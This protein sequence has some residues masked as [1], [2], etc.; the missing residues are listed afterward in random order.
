MSKKQIFAAVPRQAIYSPNHVGNDAAIFNAVIDRIRKVGHEVN[1]YTEEEFQKRELS[2]RFIFSMVRCKE[3]I[4]RLQQYEDKGCIA[5][6]SGYGIENCTRERMTRLLIEAG[7]PHPRSLFLQKDDEVPADVF[8][9][10][11]VKRADFHAIHKE[12]VTYVRHAEELKGLLSEYAMRG[13]E[14]V[15]V[16]EHL[17]GDLIKFYGVNGTDFFYWFYPFDMKHSK[18]G[19]EKINGAPTGIPFDEAS[20][21]AN[22]NKAATVL[23]VDVYGGDAIVGADGTI[24]IIDFNDWPSFAPCREAAADAISERILKKA[25]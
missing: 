15:V 14:R 21:R 13:I 23:K 16:N 4:M 12:D 22:C 17:E 19:L 24:R 3:S 25:E 10:C 5:V 1:V 18:F 20:F 8:S 7:V 11:W 6:N 9:P 2:E